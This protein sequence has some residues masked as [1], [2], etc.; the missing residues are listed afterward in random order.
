MFGRCATFDEY[1][2]NV[3]TADGRTGFVALMPRDAN[4]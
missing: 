4:R 2:R 1:F 3:N